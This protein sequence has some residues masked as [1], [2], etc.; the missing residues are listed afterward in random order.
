MSAEAV[1]AW[2][3]IF[4]IL[5][6]GAT[7]S[8]GGTYYFTERRRG[9]LEAAK[10]EATA[11]LEKEKADAEATRARTAQTVAEFGAN[12]ELNKYIDAR[13]EKLVE[14][15]TQPMHEEIERLR[16]SLAASGARTLAMTRILRAIASQWPANHPGP[17]LD[18]HDIA[19]V[20]DTIPSLFL[21]GTTP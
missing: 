2:I 3:R 4:G 20:E 11:K 12:I 10:A 17:K 5:V 1:D 16:Q 15:Q 19:E 6:V 13:V 7:A 9:R 21:K 8:G 14:D 18:P